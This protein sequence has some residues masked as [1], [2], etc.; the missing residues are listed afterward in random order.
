M[1]K[2]GWY[3]NLFYASCSMIENYL[4]FRDVVFVNKRFTKT[5]FNR[6]LV[7]FCGVNSSGKSV[8][9]GVAILAKEDDE[10]FEF[11]MTHFRQA[12]A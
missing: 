6:V 5:R 4:S 1:E 12:L 9:F 7:L 8:L 3:N 10:S 11:A 2:E